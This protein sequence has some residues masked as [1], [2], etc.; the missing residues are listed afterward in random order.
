MRQPFDR[1]LRK[2]VR[3]G[4]FTEVRNCGLNLSATY[5]TIDLWS[6]FLMRLNLSLE[7]PVR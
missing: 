5:M 2:A 6:T 7:R 1:R 4:T 3:S